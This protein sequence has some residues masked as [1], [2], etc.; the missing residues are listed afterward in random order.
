MKRKTKIIATISDRHCDV[1][2]L[3]SLFDAGMDVVRINS[4]HATV[5]S[6]DLI[7]DNV[8][9][10]S[11]HIAL[12]IDTKGPDIR[13]T[14]MAAGH[15]DGIEVRAGDAVRITG[16]DDNTPSSADTIY[17]NTSL[18]YDDVPVG[19]TIL[20]DDGSIAFKVVGKDNGALNC[21]VY[22]KGV[23]KS[24]KN[25]NIPG[26]KIKLPSVSERD[27]T[28][29]DWAVRREIDFIAHS[30]VRGRDDIL[31]VKGL[32]NERGS[33]IKIIS[34]IENQD[35][36]DNLDE[37]LAETYGVMVAR[38]DLGVEVR[39]EELPVLQR[40]IVRKCIEHKV[41]VIIATQMLQSM[42]ENPRPTRA[43]VSDI[44]SAVYQRADA[45]MLSAE[46]A[47]G[48]YP[49]ESVN[50]MGRIAAEVETD[51]I[52]AM[53]MD[54]NAV[55]IDN[56]V[57][58]QL[59]RSAVRASRNLPVKAVVIDTMTGRTGRYLAAFRGPRSV[60]AMCYSKSVMRQ[61][62]LSFGIIPLYCEPSTDHNSFLRNALGSL[63][64]TW[65]LD[66]QDLIVVMGGDFGVAS[67]ASF[68]EIA[69]IESLESKVS[70]R[71]GKANVNRP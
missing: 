67:G 43:E 54:N 19:A 35:G 8:R 42:M 23:V 45:V 29:I 17:L 26:V 9:K 39:E 64:D 12:M 69:T 68:I 63:R 58:A 27:K 36:V 1:D 48:L 50:T 55:E 41:P 4:A 2:F 46:T 11:E 10:V 37:I 53:P 7:V 25:V 3:K 49:V 57:T 30:F 70:G 20:V 60:F 71:F 13:V 21:T 34:K 44:A 33:G 15:E 65:N 16:T 5:E 31:A 47:I 24:H 38:G 6:A 51:D 18:I 52:N 22:N 28:F 32:L 40:R 66:R 14:A 59:A 56:E 61:L 62:A